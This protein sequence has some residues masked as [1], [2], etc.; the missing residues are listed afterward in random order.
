MLACTVVREDGGGVIAVV[1][2][3]CPTGDIPPNYVE[4]YPYFEIDPYIFDW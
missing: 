2:F 1:V 4:S 3:P